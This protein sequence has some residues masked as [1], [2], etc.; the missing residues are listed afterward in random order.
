MKIIYLHHSGFIVE[1]DKN[2]LVFDAITYI[3]PQFLKKGRRKYF[4]ASHAHT[5]HFSQIIYNYGTDFDTRYILS[6]DITR[7]GGKKTT[8]IK[9]YEHLHYDDIK[10]G[11]VEI[12]TFGSTDQG[13]SFLVQAEGKVIFHAGD[14]NWWDWSPDARP[15][16][17]R[18]AEERD[19]KAEIAKIKDFLE[20]NHRK[21]NV[22]FVPVDSRLGRS[23]TK[24]A[25]YF[26]DELHPQILAPMHCWDEY[27]VVTDLQQACYGKDVKILTMSK[28]N[29]IIYAD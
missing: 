10:C 14:L 20:T 23:A 1:L 3:Q 16:I 5:D 18:A 25:E 6:D 26:V 27:S 29:E 24:A 4:F 21:I 28:R 11:P 12:D 15:E 13:V 9:P 8:F 22:A 7:R 2:T 17:D 19:Y